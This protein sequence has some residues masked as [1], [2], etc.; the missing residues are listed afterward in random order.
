MA[1]AVL[2]V[3]ARF[4]DE[5]TPG[6]KKAEASI[7]NID[8]QTT[9]SFYHMQNEV[10]KSHKAI[11]H[12]SE[13][14]FEH[15]KGH[16]EMINGRLKSFINIIPMMGL[17]MAE[18]AGI[19]FLKHQV[20]QLAEFGEG[21]VKASAKTGLSTDS[22]QEWNY[23]AK[24]TGGSLNEMLPGFKNLA[25]NAEAA[26]NANSAA[27]K[28]FHALGIEVKDSSGH[29]KSMSA[30]S[31]DTID[32]LAGMS[33]KAQ[34]MALS[35]QLLGRSSQAFLPLLA[36]GKEG[37]KEMRDEAGR[38]GIV[39]GSEA[40]EKAAIF[41]DEMNKL[42]EVMQATKF[43][44]VTPMVEDMTKALTVLIGTVSA[45]SK[46]WS[47]LNDNVEKSNQDLG[48]FST[49]LMS[50][51]DVI[52]LTELGLKGIYTDFQLITEFFGTA[53]A[54]SIT[55]FGHE[56]ELLGEDISLVSK[57]AKIAWE[58]LSH[59]S[60]AKEGLSQIEKAWDDFGKR[61]AK[62]FGDE[63]GDLNDYWEEYKADAVKH[64]EEVDA[65]ASTVDKSLRSIRKSLSEGEKSKVK[66][67]SG[68]DASDPVEG[69]ENKKKQ[70][71]ALILA[72]EE[73]FQKAKNAETYSGVML[74]IANE[75][76]A[77]TKRMSQFEAFSE[78]SYLATDI[79]EQK[80]RDLNNK[81]IDEDLKA[82]EE[83]QK[84]EGEQIKY[85]LKIKNDAAK[86]EKKI[87]LEKINNAKDVA[88]N[89]IQGMDAFYSNSKK[90]ALLHKTLAIA[91]IE[92]DG[93]GAAAKA[94]LEMGPIMGPIMAAAIEIK[95]QGLA[96]KASSQHFAMGTLNA[97]GGR[98]LV[99]ENG[100]EIVDL[101][102]GSQVH[103]NSK[104]QG[105]MGNRTNIDVGGIVINLS[106]SATD[107]DGRL[108]ADAV[109]DRLK[110]LAID[111]REIN[112]RRI[113]A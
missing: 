82:I 84:K 105:M 16:V 59:P 108:I 26:T 74:E 9:S 4:I 10:L 77:Y 68:G 111:L 78:E 18:F 55:S 13:S 58:V 109:E 44:I 17:A 80:L 7:I 46:I 79:H 6:L 11:E 67:E 53:G 36:Q 27:A 95:T 2:S 5:M 43:K 21:M 56:W 28:T 61:R 98:A 35:Q 100:P 101:P 57:I 29:L 30:I 49:L 38:L 64:L 51:A 3:E 85:D 24:L 12:S 75:N 19:E 99:G 48:I 72:L 113:T 50:V 45:A 40:V 23:A 62:I 65:S 69:G 37:M 81:W 104:S 76:A 60:E 91:Q 110:K 83:K 1:D 94:L 89:L 93:A 14:T 54:M 107:N 33:N 47:P 102:A 63:K 32:A 34:Q 86:E 42:S 22:L 73:E 106:G 88:S 70:H 103:N 97:P 20:E 31:N 15:M 92:I 25:K 39:M 41:E 90:N 66:S 52:E 8:K 96:Y 112:Y 87:A 71:D